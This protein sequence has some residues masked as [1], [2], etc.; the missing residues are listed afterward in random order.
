M[1]GREGGDGKKGLRGGGGGKSV[2]QDSPGYQRRPARISVDDES[3]FSQR[4]PAGN[5]ANTLQ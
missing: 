2:L 5:G 4:I 3:I 1:T